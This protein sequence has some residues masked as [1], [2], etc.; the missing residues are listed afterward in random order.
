MWL[1]FIFI[2][3]LSSHVS[4]LATAAT[5]PA[6]FPGQ[7]VYPSSAPIIVPT[8]PQQP[9][10]AKREKKPVS[11]PHLAHYRARPARV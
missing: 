7:T 11:V 1:I 9:P 3:F 4:L 2:F 10:P 5:G 8:A 6:Y